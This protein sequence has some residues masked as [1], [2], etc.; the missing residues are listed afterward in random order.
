MSYCS[1]DCPHLS[2]WIKKHL[3]F[4]DL[5]FN[6]S[7][8]FKNILPFRFNIVLFPVYINTI[9]FMYAFMNKLIHVQK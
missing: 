5:K 9:N 6:I 4:L 2:L 3:L 1:F 8:I 7:F